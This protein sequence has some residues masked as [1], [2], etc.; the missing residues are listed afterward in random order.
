MADF[1]QQISN[2]KK[3][4]TYDY[5]FDSEGNEVLNPS[6]SIFQQVYFALPISVYNYND[7]K[8]LAFYD[9]T[10]TE[11]VPVS[12][13]SSAVSSSQDLIDQL[14][15][16]T[17]QNSQLQNQLNILIDNNQVDTSS[18][19]MQSIENTIIGLRISL[20]QGSVPSDF[21]DVYPY[22]PI[23]VEQQLIPI[24]PTG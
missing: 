24:Q 16:I 3:Y 2:F 10:F 4:G 14:N 7:S 6:S 5:A 22:N 17:Y 19:D 18:A 21:Q 20:G 11:F 13:T 12:S 23:P 9:P 8:I 15:A 1:S